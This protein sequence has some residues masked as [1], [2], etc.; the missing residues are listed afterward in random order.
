MTH[1]P[2]PPD[3]G[4][5]DHPD[6]LPDSPVP[7]S[8]ALDKLRDA[9]AAHDADLPVSAVRERLAEQHADRRSPP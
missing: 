9:A 6:H 7:V 2:L 8:V 1:T 4:E 5:S 3:D